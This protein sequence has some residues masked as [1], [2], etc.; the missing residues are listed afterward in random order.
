M[1]CAEIGPRTRV[2]SR[3]S[4]TG[5]EEPVGGLRG[6]HIVASTGRAR[7]P[8]AARDRRGRADSP[9]DRRSVRT[10]GESVSP[11]A[12]DACSRA[13]ERRY[14][15]GGAGDVVGNERAARNELAPRF[16]NSCSPRSATG[17]R[18]GTSSPRA[19][20]TPTATLDLVAAEG[21]TDTLLV[22]FSMGGAVSIGPRRTRPSTRCSG[23][24]PGF[25]TACRSTRS[26][27]SGSTSSTALGPLAAR[28]PRCRAPRSPRAASSGRSRWERPV[29]PADPARPPRRG[30]PRRN[31][32]LVRLPRWRGVG[33]RPSRP[34]S[35]DTRERSPRA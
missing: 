33:R 14:G 19:S 4:A 2:V 28:C 27:A 31:G 32:E 10:G 21:A 30:R 13:R 23:S 22:G 16:P 5:C 9:H 6:L 15:E 25:R 35:N 8:C 18:R 34:S 20:T 7:R 17:S 1:K 26:A 12:V 29:V 11:T 24:R 3:R